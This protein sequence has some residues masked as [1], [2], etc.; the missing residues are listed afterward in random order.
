MSQGEF[1]LYQTEDAQTR[2]QLRLQDETVWVTQKQLAELYQVSVPTIN[3]HLRTVFQDGELSADRTIRKFRIVAREAAREVERLVDHYNLEVILHVGY[4]VRSHRG[5][6]FRRWATEQLKSY[7]EKGFLLD[8]E[9][10]KGSQDSGYFEELLARIRD[11]RS[12]EKEFW[13]KVLDIYATSIDYDPNTEAARQF[14]AT[15]QNKMHWAAHGHTAAELIALRADAQMPHMGLTSWTGATK[16]APVRK[17]DIG[18]AKNYLNAEELETL[19]R[20]VTAYIEVAELQARAQHAM[21]MQDWA[22][23]LDNFLRMTRKDIL[24]HAGKVSAEAAREKA[25]QAY[26][27]YQ[28]QTRNLPS[29]VEKDFEVTIAQPVKRIEK[30]RKKNPQD[31][32]KKEKK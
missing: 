16:G 19:N 11:I 15:V 8:D 13:R 9:R 31:Q 28:Q 7:L 23:E 5:A 30:N 4:R 3:G 2:V 32:H 12:S 25:E 14:F 29:Q 6:Q 22:I 24:T 20:I 1:L 18:I 10:F 26:T 27:Q 21:T 17:A